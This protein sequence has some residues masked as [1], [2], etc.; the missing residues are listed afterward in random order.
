MEGSSFHFDRLEAVT[1]GLL[2]RSWTE[3]EAALNQRSGF[4]ELFALVK[5]GVELLLVV[6][7]HDVDFSDRFYCLLCHLGG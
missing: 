2:R 6:L 7:D 1:D 3:Q 4:A 5:E